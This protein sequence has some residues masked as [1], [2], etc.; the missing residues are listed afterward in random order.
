MTPEWEERPYCIPEGAFALFVHLESRS[1][2][3]SGTTPHRNAR[4]L[5][6]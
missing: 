2:V 3:I 5:L 6:Q 1:G 4:L